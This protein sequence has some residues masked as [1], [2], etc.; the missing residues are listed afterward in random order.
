LND[1][2]NRTGCSAAQ[3][4]AAAR[5]LGYGADHASGRPAEGLIW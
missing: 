1:G 5:S 3:A 4:A 2:D